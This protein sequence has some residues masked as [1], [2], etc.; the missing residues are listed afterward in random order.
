MHPSEWLK[1]NKLFLGLAADILT[2]GGGLLLARDAF[3]HLADL[4]R[5]Q[6]EA[7]FRQRFRRLSAKMRDPREAEAKEAVRWAVRGLLLLVVGFVCELAT[8][9]AE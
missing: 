7:A 5:D 6:V 1:A 9:F 2:F 3:F 8:R 4:R